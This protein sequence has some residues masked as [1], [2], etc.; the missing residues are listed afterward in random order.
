M[1]MAVLARG[2]VYLAG[3]VTQK[4]LPL[5]ETSGFL[6]AFNAKAEHADLVRRMPVRVVADPE[7]GLRGAV[8]AARQSPLC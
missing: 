6:A 3:G 1:A 5:L 8:E 2:G 7:I 4:L